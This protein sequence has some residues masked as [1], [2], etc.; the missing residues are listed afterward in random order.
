MPSKLPK[1]TI[2]VT[3]EILH[4]MH[5]IAEYNSR[6]ANKEIETLVKKHIENFEKR[7]GKI[8]LE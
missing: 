1:F 3:P 7:N 4:K 6:S 8:K 5:Y 2:R